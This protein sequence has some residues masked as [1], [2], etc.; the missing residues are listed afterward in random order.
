MFFFIGDQ[1]FQQ[2]LLYEKLAF[3][4]AFFCHFN[5]FSFNL[6]VRF[7]L[8][9]YLSQ[10]IVGKI[11]RLLGKTIDNELLHSMVLD[12]IIPDDFHELSDQVGLC[13]AVILAACGNQGAPFHRINLI[14][15]A[16]P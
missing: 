12:R 5:R 15:Q 9:P 7:N 14:T 10:F 3:L 13:Y 2:G 8:F 1:V 16:S 11:Y 6:I 4:F